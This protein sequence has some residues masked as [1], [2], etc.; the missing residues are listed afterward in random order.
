MQQYYAIKNTNL[1][2]I[3]TKFEATQILQLFF[4]IL[5]NKST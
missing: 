5:R 2:I 1:L 4:V 3:R